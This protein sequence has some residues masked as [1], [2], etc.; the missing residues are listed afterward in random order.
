M[1][2][3]EIAAAKAYADTAASNAVVGIPGAIAQALADAK[4]YTDK[5]VADETS[6]TQT[7]TENGNKVFSLKSVSTDL[8]INGN[9]ELILFGGYAV[10]RAATPEA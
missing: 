3:N 9:D 5:I 1:L 7:T 2:V 4:A 10:D 6:I 8:L